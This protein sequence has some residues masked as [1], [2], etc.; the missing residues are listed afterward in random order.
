[1]KWRHPFRWMLEQSCLITLLIPLMLGIAVTEWT[2]LLD[3]DTTQQAAT[4]IPFCLASAAILALVSLVTGVLPHKTKLQSRLKSRAGHHV[5]RL[6]ILNFQ[7][8]TFNLLLPALMFFIGASSAL[9]HHVNNQTSWPSGIHQWTAVVADAPRPTAKTY[10]IPLI[11]SRGHE[12]PHRKVMLSVMKSALPVPPNVGDALVFNAQIREPY[13]YTSDRHIS[14]VNRQFDYAKWLG[15][16]GFQGQAFVYSQVQALC[17]HE[18][19]AL[20][21]ALPWW[22]RLRIWALQKRSI[23]VKKYYAN[24]SGK[25]GRNIGGS[26]GDQEAAVLAALT[27]GDRS[28]LRTDVREIF[29]R[30]GAS[31]VLALS[32]LHL[33]ILATLLMMLLWPLGGIAATRQRC[34]WH[35][36]LPFVICASLLWSF[37]LLTGCSV[38]VVRSALMITL[39]FLL[40]LRGEGFASLNNVIVA[41]TLILCVSPLALMDVGFQLSFLSVFFII[42]LFPYY[43]ERFL[44]SRSSRLPRVRQWAL[45]FLYIT[46]V[47][48]LATAPIVACVFGRL[49]L[50]FLLTNLLVIPCAYVLLTGALV[51]FA[52]SWC[53][54]AASAIGWLLS[55]TTKLMLG[56]LEWISSLPLSSVEVSVSPLSALMMYPLILAGFAW[57]I[58]HQRIYGYSF[59]ILLGIVVSLLGWGV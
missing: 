59:F 11:I 31:H 5:S 1:M 38:S 13:N 51:F 33:G 25:D 48:Q 24:V 20:V 21:A 58:A 45:N 43:Q 16:Q 8:S 52:L 3:R 42:W 56:S 18:S 22:D 35:R 19:N 54:A 6:S 29:A 32:G 41:A 37:V 12:G 39:T 46:V 9:I 15:R 7:F 28:G 53:A 26:E 4:L 2:G 40:A 34:H 36:Y 30:T 50:L 57:L 14:T 44:G 47:A 55:R 49:P 17:D 23:L 27:L 10:R